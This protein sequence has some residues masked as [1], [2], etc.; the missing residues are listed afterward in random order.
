MTSA[1]RVRRHLLASAALIGGALSPLVASAQGTLST[2]GLGYPQGELSTRALSTGGALGET[3]P[4]STVNPAAVGS[5]GATTLYFQYEPEYRSVKT[6]SASEATNTVRYPLMAVGIQMGEK[7]TIGLSSSMFLDRTWATS[8][9]TTEIVNADTVTSTV[10]YRS[11][12]SI[13][14]LRFATAYAPVNW[15]RLGVGLHAFSGSNQL[16]RSRQFSDTATFG[17]FGDTTEMSYRG[18]GVS[19]GAEVIIPSWFA[20]GVSA[21]HGGILKAAHGDTTYSRSAHIPDRFGASLAYIGIANTTLS[22]RSSLEK[23]S[24]LGDLVSAASQP[25][26]AWDT[27]VGVDV[28]GPRWGSSPVMLRAGMRWRDLPFP[29]AGNQVSEKS[30]AFGLG[31]YFARGHA[32]ADVAAVHSVRN[33]AAYSERA[34]TVSVG[35]SV[36]P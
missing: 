6:G 1:G 14:D 31:T 17:S 34:W 27:G 28:A 32:S 15:L 20:I 26:D 33:A 3:D 7:W 19:G 13:S 25:K 5:F 22:V 11:V 12:G 24:S 23:W 9:D 16:G 21:R 18:T 10:R 35:L 30:I 29:A 2:Q 8:M 36:R 4:T